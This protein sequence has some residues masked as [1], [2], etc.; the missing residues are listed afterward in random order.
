MSGPWD[1][2]YAAMAKSAETGE[3]VR[4]SWSA[5]SEDALTCYAI[6]T[7]ESRGGLVFWGTEEGDDESAPDR[8][9][10]VHL[11]LAEVAS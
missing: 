3:H 10:R 5:E 11:T 4:M 1:A 6:G 2:A 7:A 9:W 8:P